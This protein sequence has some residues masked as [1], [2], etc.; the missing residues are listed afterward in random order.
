MKD[1]SLTGTYRGIYLKASDFKQRESVESQHAFKFTAAYNFR[2]NN[3][4][5][6]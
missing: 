1:L 2:G 5:G 3:T 4:L 6:A